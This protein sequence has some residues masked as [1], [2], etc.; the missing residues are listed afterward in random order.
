MFQGKAILRF[1]LTLAICAIILLIPWQV[2][3]RGYASVFRMGG[4]IL[5]SR[6]WIWPEGSVKFLDLESDRLY[7]DIDRVTAGTLPPT[8]QP[9]KAKG[10][11]DTLMVLRNRETPA[12]FGML[13]I[14]SRLVGYWSIAWL[15]ALLIAKPMSWRRRG[16]A[17]LWGLLWVHAF[18]AVRLT[19]K[20]SAD[21]FGAA[22]KYALFAPGE[23]GTDMLR[24]LVE[25][26][27]ENPS[28]TFVVPTFIWFLVAFDRSEWSSFRQQ[29]LG[30][31]DQQDG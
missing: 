20:L 8:F 12:S 23:F 6:F 24:R 17:A 7:R 9:P 4:N 11:L 5:F 31:D 3:V 26:F 27:V 16:K 19:I 21:G 30:V 29:V 14:G 15:L 1:A 10:V 18:I 2:V 25:V 22:K 13:R 28:V